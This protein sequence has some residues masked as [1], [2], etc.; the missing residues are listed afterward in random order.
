MENTGEIIELLG[1]IDEITR[2]EYA[3]GRVEY[4]TY[5]GITERLKNVHTKLKNLG[6]IGDVSDSVFCF[7]RAAGVSTCKKLCKWCSE[8]QDFEENER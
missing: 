3:S 6:V 4:A 7:D 2:N 8:N 1:E 5:V